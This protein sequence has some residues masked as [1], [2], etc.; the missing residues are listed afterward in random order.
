MV[1]SVAARFM[2]SPPLC[3]R[4]LVD[5]TDWYRQ[6][7]MTR[8]GRVQTAWIP[9]RYAVAGATLKLRDEDGWRVAS[10]GARQPYTAVRFRERIDLPSLE[11]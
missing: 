3:Y 11:G 7:R 10:V 9:E 4:S 8:A 1:Q 2:A 6:C 5:L